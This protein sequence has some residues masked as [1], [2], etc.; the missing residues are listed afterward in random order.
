MK[1]KVQQQQ[2]RFR[3]KFLFFPFFFFFLL[4]ASLK[5][6]PSKCQ[7]LL[8]PP[9]CS[10]IEDIRKLASLGC[11]VD[12]VSGFQFFSLIFALLVEI[13]R[14]VGQK[15]LILRL[16]GLRMLF[17]LGYA[18]LL[19]HGQVGSEGGKISYLD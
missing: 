11:S 19:G 18:L 7:S 3:R 5:V 9:S 10:Y 1:E 14:Q 4:S 17:Y 13:S 16:L 15:K 12:R 8:S 6:M 2:N